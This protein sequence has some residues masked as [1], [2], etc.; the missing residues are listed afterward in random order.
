VLKDVLKQMSDKRSIEIKAKPS[1][2]AVAASVAKKVKNYKRQRLVLASSPNKIGKKFLLLKKHG[3]P[4]GLA[5]AAVPAVHIKK[6]MKKKRKVY[7]PCPCGGEQHPGRCRGFYYWHG[8]NI[9]APESSSDDD[10]NDDGLNNDRVQ[11]DDKADKDKSKAKSKVSETDTEND[12]GD[13]DKRSEES[14]E[15]SQEAKEEKSKAKQ[16]NTKCTTTTIVKQLPECHSCDTPSRSLKPCNSCKEEVC[17]KCLKKCESILC[18][19]MFCDDCQSEYASGEHP[20]KIE[21]EEGVEE[22]WTC[23]DEENATCRLR[24]LADYWQNLFLEAVDTHA[25][26]V[27]S[28]GGGGRGVGGRG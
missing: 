1:S 21:P 8:T 25:G 17:K 19:V 28:G 4:V 10:E 11:D 5:A 15:E 16:C 12:R 24:I 23:G 2:S 20:Q 13:V 26:G 9:K 27:G 22:L 7:R 18:D 3:A 6:G 14:S